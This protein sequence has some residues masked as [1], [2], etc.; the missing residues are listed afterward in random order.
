MRPN[1][2]GA[3][4]REV[5][6]VRLDAVEE[7][8]APG[9]AGAPLAVLFRYTCHATAMGA[10]NDLITADYPGARRLSSS[11]RTAAGPPPSSSRA[12]RGTC[13]P[14]LASPEGG[15]RSADWPE[16]ARLGR[17]LGAA[18]VGA[19]EQAAFAARAGSAAGAGGGGGPAAAGKTVELPFDPSPPADELRAL[20]PPGRWPDGAASPR[21]SASG[22]RAPPARWPRAR[23]RRG[24][25]PRC[26][27]FAS[28][29]PGW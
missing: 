15:F 24:R 14:N 20:P 6:V 28:G 7:R 17:E 5:V 25:P 2:E 21:R 1:P 16:L 27:S 4:D 19:A 18:T 3:V 23:C 10:Q 9:A 26:R 13:G 29:T 22:R 12:A 11:R 8:T